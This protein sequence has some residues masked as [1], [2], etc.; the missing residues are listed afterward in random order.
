MAE[1][2]DWTGYIFV[3]KSKKRV[4]LEHRVDP[5]E[6]KKNRPNPRTVPQIYNTLLKKS[7]V[8]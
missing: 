6:D 5:S 3:F 4:N 1:S 8:R 7:C 2:L